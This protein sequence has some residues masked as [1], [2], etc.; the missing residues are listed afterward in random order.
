MSVRVMGAV[1]ELD[2]RPP[3]KH[4]LLALADHA[5]HDGGNVHPSVGLVSWKTG[6]SER[7]VQRIIAQLERAGIL[8]V[9]DHADG[10][11][12]HATLYRIRT[13]K[14]V[15]LS[16]F[17]RAKKGVKTPPIAGVE[18]DQKGDIH[19]GERVT[20]GTPKGDTGVTPTVK[21][22]P[23]NHQETASATPPA[24]PASVSPRERFR[25]SYH[26][27]KD[28]SQKRI[29][30]VGDLFRELTGAEPNHA[31]LA[32][33]AKDLN[34]GYELGLLCFEVAARDVGDDPHDYLSALV[35]RRKAGPRVNALPQRRLTDEEVRSL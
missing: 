19:D 13:E 20:S 8:E 5:D 2:L 24:E 31:R 16:P 3:A 17:I 30:A 7:Q 9:V 29:G 32:K 33:L 10:G 4:V 25:I 12:G 34:S 21:E 14:G 28:N 15:K 35:R 1:W 18:P 11:R 23:V 22:P 26:D 27:A 6:Y